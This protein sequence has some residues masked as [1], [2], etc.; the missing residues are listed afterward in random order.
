MANDNN[1]QLVEI[2]N[3]DMVRYANRELAKVIRDIADPNKKATMAREMT[4]KIKF[5][6]NK[7]RNAAD[8]SYNVTSKM[9]NYEEN[10]DTQI[11]L[12]RDKLGEPIAKT[13]Q[14]NQTEM[15]QPDGPKQAEAPAS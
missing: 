12:G 5:K 14:P 6:P 8:L 4:I 15:F 3:G 9:A 2:D 11:Y 10:D 1:L 13:Y 7:A